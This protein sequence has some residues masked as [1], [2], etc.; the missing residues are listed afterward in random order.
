[1][2]QF[3]SNVTLALV[4]ASLEA[5]ETSTY[6]YFGTKQSLGGVIARAVH[7]VF[8]ALDVFITTDT[9]TYS[10]WWPGESPVGVVFT[11]HDEVYDFVNAAQSRRLAHVRKLIREA[12]Q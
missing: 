10:D 8:P 4:T 11:K 9:A 6:L 2:L 12:R 3:D 5:P 7:S 1:M